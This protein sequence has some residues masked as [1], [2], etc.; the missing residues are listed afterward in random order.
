MITVNLT[1][2][3]EENTRRAG[4]FLLAP[5]DSSTPLILNEPNNTFQQT[6]WIEGNSSGNIRYQSVIP[7]NSGEVKVVKNTSISFELSAIDLSAAT[8]PLTYQW[9]KDGA[10]LYLYNKE[11]NGRGLSKIEITNASVQNSGTYV[12]KVIN[13]YGSVESIPFT[14]V[15]VDPK[16]EIM[17]YRNLIVNSD[18]DGG[19]ANWEGDSDIITSQ[20]I[21]GGVGGNHLQAFGSFNFI[22]PILFRPNPYDNGQ[23]LRQID[24][25]PERLSMEFHFSMLNNYGL[26]FKRF[27]DRYNN[28]PDFKNPNVYTIPSAP[29]WPDSFHP[30]QIVQNEDL[31]ESSNYAGFFPG[32]GWMDKY[33]RNKRL[34]GLLPEVENK[35]PS[36]FTRDRIKFKKFDGKSIIKFS[37]NINIAPVA[38]MINGTVA[39]IAYITSQFFAY[40]GAGI[41]G[42]K[43]K[44]IT[45]AGPIVYNYHIAGSEQL[46]DY[47]AKE[48][49]RAQNVAYLL[50]QTKNKDIYVK[51]SANTPIEITPLVDDTTDITI[52]YLHAD[53]RILKSE[54]IPGPRA[55][56]VW[57]IKEKVYFPLT[58]HFLSQL[59]LNGDHPIKVFGQIYTYTNAINALFNRGVEGL[60]NDGPTPKTDID[61]IVDKNA[62]FILKKYKI[63]IEATQP[64]TWW[65]GW[66]A[67]V[68]ANGNA[69]TSETNHQKTNRTIIDKG[70]AAMFGVGRTIKVPTDTTSVKITVA[71]INTSEAANDQ[72][73]ELKG[74]TK[75]EIYCN[76][77]G[78]TQDTS[79]RTSE[80]GN[81]RC[82][83]T[84]MKFQLF[85]NNINI[86]ENH[87]TYNIPPANFTVLGMQ[88]EKYMDTHAFNTA[89]YH[90]NTTV[91]GAAAESAAATAGRGSAVNPGAA[92]TV[93][94]GGF[95]VDPGADIIYAPDFNYNLVIPQILP[96][97]IPATSPF[98][99]NQL[100]NSKDD[101]LKSSLFEA[102]KIDSLLGAESG[103]G[104]GTR[105][106]READ[107]RM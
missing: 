18:G 91:V 36:Y 65:A 33:N 64:N 86:S 43:I 97:P 39:G 35:S 59:T 23:T 32:L 72:N 61:T 89:Y 9:S 55:K 38:D 11:E 5:S 16:K 104:H 41:T 54:T 27:Y 15:V 73:P 62:N 76:D 46:Y 28:E 79:R 37:Q 60:F 1:S 68:E 90:S 4:S 75:E 25:I 57:A 24:F 78:K 85:D 12:C 2:Y 13:Q 19:L 14:I 102:K 17:L 107:G 47:Y 34:I 48:D 84:K 69:N 71:F 98:I 105:A 52:D 83:I 8:D 50:G 95:A 81:P 42:Y 100:N 6:S 26:F 63:H 29:S 3:N 77:F 70:A 67:G 45:D 103:D 7:S 92:A 93:T 80:Y 51:L 30:P 21:K 49:F 96:E 56:E 94:G 87:L 40:V 22:G 44:V 10:Q 31:W 82:G 99:Q 20:F 58:L 101:A 74:W 106:T 88:K 66:N 53:G